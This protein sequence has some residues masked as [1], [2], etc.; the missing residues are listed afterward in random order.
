MLI[1]FKDDFTR[2]NDWAATTN[3]EAIVIS[4]RNTGCGAGAQAGSII[5][6]GEW[7]GS[8][9]YN[10]NHVDFEGSNFIKTKYTGGGPINDDDLFATGEVSK[11]PP[12]K[13][14]GYDTAMVYHDKTSLANQN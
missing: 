8:V 14:A 3:S 12:K 10:D 5:N 2:Q 9:G 6:A 1:L 11:S 7:Q 13:G 4:D